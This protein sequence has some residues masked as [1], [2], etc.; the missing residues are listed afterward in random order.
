MAAL[1]HHS[2]SPS[3]HKFGAC[4]GPSPPAG[5][6]PPSLPDDG[7]AARCL[8]L[9]PPRRFGERELEH[10]DAAAL[11]KCLTRSAHIDGSVLELSLV[12]PC[13]LR[14]RVKASSRLCGPTGTIMQLPKNHTDFDL[15]SLLGAVRRLRAGYCAGDDGPRSALFWDGDPLPTVWREMGVVTCGGAGVHSAYGDAAASLTTAP[16]QQRRLP[17]QPPARRWATCAVVGGAPSLRAAALGPAIDAHA[18][19]VRFND[20]PFGGAWS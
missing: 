3:T 9:W 15:C 6:F 5:S 7:A 18:A 4:R 14:A 16:Q 2:A 8:P 20:N 12:P 10:L 1:R 17:R 11:A 13:T 19:V